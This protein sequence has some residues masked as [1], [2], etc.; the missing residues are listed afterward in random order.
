ML[1]LVT[2]PT[3][4]AVSTADAKAW[5]RVTSSDEDAQI[6]ALVD[7]AAGAVEQYLGRRL[8]TQTWRLTLDR[9]PAMNKRQDPWWDGV[10]EG[11]LSDMFGN[12]N[13]IE[14]GLA[15]VSAV[16]SFT[17]YDLSDTAQ[18]FSSSAYFLDSSSAPARI[19]L[20]QGQI[21]PTSIRQTKA[22]E[23]L[24]TVGYGGRDSVPAPILVAIKQTLAALYENRGE[25]GGEGM[26][27]AGAKELLAPY[28]V[29]RLV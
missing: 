1:E 15:P 29:R 9:C 24:F 17:Y 20:K 11:A 2:A 5:L 25:C 3:T 12:P 27:P 22:I 28:V 21:W 4:K 18:T 26:I 7:A 8:L 16:T 23:I 10:R 14:L 6:D 13:F 19:V